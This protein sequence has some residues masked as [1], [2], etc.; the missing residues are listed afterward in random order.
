[1]KT[2]LFPGQGAQAKG[3]GK[4]LFQ[5]YPKLTQTASDILG[6]SIEELCL[7]DPDKNLKFTQYTQ[8]ALYVVSALG[9]FKR[10]DEH[11]GQQ[12]LADFLA[13]HSLGE[14]NALL[15]AGVF[16]FE[17]GL[18]LVQKRGQLMAA[19][20]GGTMAAV[21]GI[22]AEKV[23]ELLQANQ[24]SDI[25]LANYN[26]PTQLVI[27]GKSESIAKA[28]K[29][30]TS[31]GTRCVMLN[32]S[33]PF[34]SRYMK[35]AQNEFMTFLRDFQFAAPK[36]PVIANSTARPYQANKI[37]Q[38]LA[39][40][41]A[42]SVRW[43]DT[44]RYLM[45]QG[46][47]E[48]ME[49]IEIGSTMLSKMV[50]E[51][52]KTSSPLDLTAEI[53]AANAAKPAAPA[54]PAIPQPTASASPA[55]VAAPVAAPAPAPVATAN[56]FNIQAANLGSALFRQRYGLRYAYL[57]GAMYR[58]IASAELVTC[59]GKAGFLGFFGT[60]GLPLKEIE[61]GIL[62]IQAQLKNGEPYGMNLLA[63]YAHPPT[64][65]ATIDLYL[66]Y[67][68]KIVEAAAFMQMTP[69]LVLFRLKGLRKG[70]D[71]KT[72]CDNRIMAKISRP[73]VAEVFM[74]PAPAHVVQR[75]LDEGA[76]TKE[77]AELAKT[78]PM[79]YD[80]CVEADSG[81]HTDGGIPSTLFPAMQQLKKTL[82]A[83][84]AYQEP[85][86]MGLAGGIGSPEAAAAAFVMG[87]DFIL[88]GSINQCTVQGGISD[89]AKRLLQDINI[90]D[91]EYAP[92]GDMFEMGSKV[93]VL[94]KG[95]FF[96]TR[97][98]KLFS[99][100]SNYDS[101]D[102]IPEK[103][104]KQL[105]NIYFKK[106]FVEIWD[107]TKAY[108]QEQGL[109]AE[110][111]KADA[112]PKHKMALVFRWYFSYSSRLSFAG[113]TEDR[114]NYQIHTGPSLGSFN[115]WVKGTEMELWPNRNVN[116][117]GEKLMLDTATFLNQRFASW[118]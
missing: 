53:A 60:G 27:A 110:I 82:A 8:P 80:I 55:P 39:D 51:I 36:I 70:S 74:S 115:Q 48:D 37:A 46:S 64:E 5:V 101:L 107:E 98:N 33:A 35:E 25:D 22:S 49:Y 11:Q 79:S 41:I 24:L 45:A 47:V 114:V 10:R 117:I 21:I 78:V 77:Q 83:K 38:T 14:Y 23:N 67:Q 86:C 72:I 32:V 40:Q 63:N 50:A 118:A 87:A 44:I 105:Q 6:Y 108:F 12:A 52:K 96:A 31:G 54:A 1:M 106:T 103:T 2:I 109:G 89:E 9:Y 61:K 71:G 111:T 57:A 95:V 15:A 69:G 13:G 3:M 20:K 93:Q 18:K 91:T 30:F 59:M 104:K 4:D 112:N 100:Y 73:E 88:T 42:G 26:T 90:Q 43:V 76:V 116:E 85:I 34:H 102:D 19:A 7:H 66:K 65:R 113:K 28:E 56:G 75:L 58:G 84:F 92:A 17:T 81:G 99:L 62:A 16:D 94:K 29:L 68:V 97:A